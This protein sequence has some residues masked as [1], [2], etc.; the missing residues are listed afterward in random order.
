MLLS[1]M[2]TLSQQLNQRL[3]SIRCHCDSMGYGSEINPPH[4]DVREQ[5]ARITESANNSLEASGRYIHNV[6][7]H[8]HCCTF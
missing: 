5:A 8:V 2:S 6:H 1:T 7:V 4:L 3:D